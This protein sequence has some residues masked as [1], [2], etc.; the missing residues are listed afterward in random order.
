MIKLQNSL[1]NT[2][3]V[4]GREF[5]IKTDF[6]YWLLFDEIRR[7]PNLQV[8]DLAFLF[9]GEMP[10]LADIKETMHR[11]M[12]FFTNPNSTPRGKG[13]KEKLMDYQEDGEFLYSSFLMAYGIDLLDKNLSLHWHQFK[14]LAIGLPK[15]TMMREVIA[16]RG[17]TDD[18]RKP[19]AIAKE[20]KRI[21]S[22]PD[23]IDEEIMREINAQMK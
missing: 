9:D 19:D 12:A 21:W 23:E 14:A 8:S 10:D 2:I 3:V 1:P 4:N 18:K 13:G 7:E 17:Y 11:L 5:S 16:M 22:L 6:R 15:H 20:L